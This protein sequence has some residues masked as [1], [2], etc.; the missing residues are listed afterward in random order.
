MISWNNK[1][2]VV[3][4]ERKVNRLKRWFMNIF[5]RN[6]HVNE[7]CEVYLCKIMKK[8]HLLVLFGKEVLIIWLKPTKASSKTFMPKHLSLLHTLPLITHW[9]DFINSK[10]LI[11]IWWEMLSSILMNWSRSIL[12]FHLDFALIPVQYP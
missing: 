11:G 9:Y 6:C 8:F 4:L 5:T 1:Y 12:F 2:I 3:D 7:L 10:I